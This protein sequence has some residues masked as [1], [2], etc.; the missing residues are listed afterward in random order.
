MCCI[1]CQR[2]RTT[3]HRCVVAVKDTVDKLGFATRCVEGAT[4]LRMIAR[5]IAVLRCEGPCRDQNGTTFGY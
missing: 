5:K 4:I 2:N 3:M 1:S